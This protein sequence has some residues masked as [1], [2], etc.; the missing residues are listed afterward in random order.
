MTKARK[1]GQFDGFARGRI[2][3]LAEAGV[4]P[5]QIAKRASKINGRKGKTDAVRKTIR[6][7]K[8][9]KGAY[10][11]RGATYVDGAVVGTLGVL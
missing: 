5:S 6:K 9:S 1:G 10:I 4:P 2:I 7:H 3:G 8:E 11:V